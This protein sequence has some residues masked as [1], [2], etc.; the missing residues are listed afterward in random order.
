M[1]IS[2]LCLGLLSAGILQWTSGGYPE[3]RS[4]MLILLLLPITWLV[5][6]WFHSRVFQLSPQEMGLPKHQI[7]RL[8]SGVIA[9]FTV[10]WGLCALI[11]DLSL[12]RYNGDFLFLWDQTLRVITPIQLFWL[13][14][15]TTVFGFVEEVFFRGIVFLSLLLMTKRLVLSVGISALVFMLAHVL[16]EQTF[17]VWNITLVGLG[18]LFAAL[19]YRTGNLWLVAGLHGGFNLAT[20][21]VKYVLNWPALNGN[22]EQITISVLQNVQYTL[23]AIITLTAGIVLWQLWRRKSNPGELQSTLNGYWQRPAVSSESV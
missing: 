13:A 12:L 23:S 8:L 16:I 20:E 10:V 7:L 9:S 2:A 22:N 6:W 1:V 11:T 15:L 14:L 17:G 3:P 4:L 19:Y 18:I 21:S 5:S